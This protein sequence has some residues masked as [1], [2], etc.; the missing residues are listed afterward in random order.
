VGLTGQLTHL[1]C[2]WELTL[3]L[4]P[5]KMSKKSI[6]KMKLLGTEKSRMDSV[7]CAIAKT[8]SAKVTNS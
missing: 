4:T 7:G 3:L 2:L 1:R 6:G 5:S 8:Q